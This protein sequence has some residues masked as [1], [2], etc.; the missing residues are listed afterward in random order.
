MA[1]DGRSRLVR[2][3]EHIGKVL[4]DS[5]L[6]HLKEV[7]PQADSPW[8]HIREVLADD[9]QLPLPLLEYKEE[10]KF[11]FNEQKHQWRDARL[12]RVEERVDIELYRADRTL[13]GSVQGNTLSEGQRNTAVLNLLLAKGEGPM[14]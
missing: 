7:H 12:T 9:R 10:L 14:H 6:L 13:V 2:A 11:Y 3:W 8:L 1:P 5:F 4:F